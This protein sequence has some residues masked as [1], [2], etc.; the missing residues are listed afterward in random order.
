M[1]HDMS[2]VMR[3][4]HLWEKA[5]ECASPNDAV[6]TILPPTAWGADQ[7][8]IP[9]LKLCQKG[10]HT[11]SAKIILSGDKKLDIIIM[12]IILYKIIHF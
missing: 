4:C 12:N 7:L 5:G 9:V 8:L 11:E 1:T 2:F 6:S 10:M 3:K